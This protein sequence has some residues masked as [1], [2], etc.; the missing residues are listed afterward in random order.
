[1]ARNSRPD[2]SAWG[3]LKAVA[4]MTPLPRILHGPITPEWLQCVVISVNT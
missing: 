1:M 4:L 3:E 2:A